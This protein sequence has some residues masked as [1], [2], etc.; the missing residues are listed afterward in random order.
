MLADHNTTKRTSSSPGFLPNHEAFGPGWS[1][2]VLTRL[3]AKLFKP[4]KSLGCHIRARTT[5]PRQSPGFRQS[6][7]ALMGRERWGRGG[8]EPTGPPW[9]HEGARPIP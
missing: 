8:T 1:G 4:I 2:R 3:L 6:N 9:S 5:I 7:T